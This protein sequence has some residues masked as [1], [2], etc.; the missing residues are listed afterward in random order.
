MQLKFD[1]TEQLRSKGILD[2]FMNLEKGTRESHFLMGMMAHS[3]T[4]PQNKEKKDQNIA[5]KMIS[6]VTDTLTTSATALFS[7]GMNSIN[8]ILPGNLLWNTFFFV[9]ATTKS[10]VSSI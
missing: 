9:M 8:F 1:F 10:Y 2:Y 5:S 3:T 6:G 4:N 7:A